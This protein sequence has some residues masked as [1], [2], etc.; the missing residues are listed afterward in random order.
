MG[1]RRLSLQRIDRGNLDRAG[2]VEIRERGVI[3]SV[4]GS[5]AL[6]GQC[7]D[8]RSHIISATADGFVIEGA[9]TTQVDSVAGG[10]R[11]RRSGAMESRTTGR[12]QDWRLQQMQSPCDSTTGDVDL[13]VLDIRAHGPAHGLDVRFQEVVP[14]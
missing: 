6:G 1:T 7:P 9:I 12:C 11:C 10:A 2:S 13:D 14:L 4:T 5:E 8:I 3:L